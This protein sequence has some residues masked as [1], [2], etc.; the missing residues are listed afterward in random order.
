MVIIGSFG[1][2]I[3]DKTLPHHPQVCTMNMLIMMLAD[4]AYIEQ[5][6][7]LRSCN[8]SSIGKTSTGCNLT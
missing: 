1:V 7:S 3:K 5:V 2:S 6:C 8:W 4:W